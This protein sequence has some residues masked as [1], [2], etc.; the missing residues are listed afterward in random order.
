MDQTYFQRACFCCFFFRRK[1]GADIKKNGKILIGIFMSCICVFFHIP[2]SNKVEQKLHSSVLTYYRWQFT[3]AYIYVSEKKTVKIL[4]YR[5][6][7]RKKKIIRHFANEHVK[8][9]ASF[10]ISNRFLYA[11]SCKTVF[12][13]F[14]KWAPSHF[15][16]NEEKKCTRRKAVPKRPPILCY[17][18]EYKSKLTLQN[19]CRKKN[20]VISFLCKPFN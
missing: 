13:S 5:H 10:D 3:V 18:H 7:K 9:F 20:E 8:M 4:A 15:T 16:K 11:S 14:W 19:E 6:E 1:K 12:F 17:A 2:K